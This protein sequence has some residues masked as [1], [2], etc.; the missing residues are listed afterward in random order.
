MSVHIS[1]TLWNLSKGTCILR[2]SS[3]LEDP[4]RSSV[5]PK[6]PRTLC[7]H[8]M[9]GFCALEVLAHS[10]RTPPHTPSVRQEMTTHYTPLTSCVP[11]YGLYFLERYT[12]RRVARSSLALALWHSVEVLV[13]S[14]G[15]G[16]RG[17]DDKHTLVC[18]EP[19]RWNLCHI[20]GSSPR[21]GTRHTVGD[22]EYDHY[23]V[24]HRVPGSVEHYD[25]GDQY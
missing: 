17:V 24:R 2:A 10:L 18:G 7:A 12:R 1:Y 11:I 22:D 5:H 9:R 20:K 19:H 13:P 23:V 6:C 4:I 15:V 21:G 8:N 14:P 16:Q 3:E 25:N